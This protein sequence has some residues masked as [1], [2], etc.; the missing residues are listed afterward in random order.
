LTNENQLVEEEKRAGIMTMADYL[1]PEDNVCPDAAH[2]SATTH[3]DDDDAAPPGKHLD[4]RALPKGRL[5]RTP[6]DANRQR[7]QHKQHL[8]QRQQTEDRALRH[9]AVV[10]G[11]AKAQARL[12]VA[13]AERQLR[14]LRN[15]QFLVSRRHAK[16]TLATLSGNKCKQGK[17]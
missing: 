12:D 14:A 3:G 16:R 9:A 13:H 2:Y 11:N 7:R 15:V 1:G 4:R 17:K 8:R 6:T 10:Q 5:E